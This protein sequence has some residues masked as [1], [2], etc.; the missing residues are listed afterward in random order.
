MY[1]NSRISLDGMLR[2]THPKYLCGRLGVGSN[3]RS[4]SD[5]QATTVNPPNNDGFY[6]TLVSASLGIVILVVNQRLA[7]LLALSDANTRDT[8]FQRN[9][10]PLVLLMIRWFARKIL[11]W[12]WGRK[13]YHLRKKDS[14]N[15]ELDL[16]CPCLSTISRVTG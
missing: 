13:F 3:R 2:T 1:S 16:N 8:S 7:L 6:I 14:N 5:R 15:G 4:A 9:T 12:K 11:R 10:L